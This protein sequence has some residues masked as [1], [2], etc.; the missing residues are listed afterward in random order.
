[1]NL[2]VYMFVRNYQIDISKQ[3]QKTNN[4]TMNFV[5]HTQTQKHLFFGMDANAFVCQQADKWRAE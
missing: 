4:Q 5:R 1:M 3:K 2:R